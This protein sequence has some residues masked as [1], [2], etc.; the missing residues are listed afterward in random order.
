MNIRAPS[1]SSAIEEI[2]KWAEH[3]QLDFYHDVLTGMG[4]VYSSC[5]RYRLLIWRIWSPH[6]QFLS[7]GMLNPSTAGHDSTDPTATRCTK[8]GMNMRQ[9]DVGGWLGWNLFAFRATHPKVMKRHID[10]VGRH[11]DAAIRLAV[12]LSRQHIAGWGTDGGFECRDLHVCRMLAVDGVE[13]HCLGLTKH[14]FP[15]HPLYV[16]FSMDPM[17][18]EYDYD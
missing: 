1:C 16:P 15:R 13:L 2:R 18:W 3:N 10:P 14:G 4:A 17:V 12:R 7:F 6:N 11:N 8:R 9:W 5:R